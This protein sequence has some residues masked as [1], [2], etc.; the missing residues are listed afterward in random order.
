[1][2]IA[3]SLALLVAAGHFLRA[4]TAAA[5][6]PGY[7][8]QDGLLAETDLDMIGASA[9]D[10]LRPH[11]ALVDRLRA[12]PGVRA[13]TLASIVPFGSARDGR[14]IRHESR[15]IRADARRRSMTDD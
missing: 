7:A 14:T 12:L 9:P 15:L 4:G 1:M 10:G 6:D 13:A 8:L 11:G 3:L 2:E 5:A